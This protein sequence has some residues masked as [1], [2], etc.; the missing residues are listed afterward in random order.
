MVLNILFTN[1]SKNNDEAITVSFKIF[2]VASEQYIGFSNC[3][4]HICTCTKCDKIL[5]VHAR[6]EN[7]L[8][9]SLG[10]TKIIPPLVIKWSAL[11]S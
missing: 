11:C 8:D 9:W 3:L 4:P 10:T 5:N 2:L 1:H 6:R 7:E